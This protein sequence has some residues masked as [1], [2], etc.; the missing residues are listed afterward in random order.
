MYGKPAARA[1]CAARAPV[2]RGRLKSV[3]TVFQTAF[4]LPSPP[5]AGILGLAPTLAAVSLGRDPTYGG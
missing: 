1:N 5:A 2:A 3:Q 4:S